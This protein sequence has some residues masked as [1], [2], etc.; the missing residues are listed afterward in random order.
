MSRHQIPTAAFRTFTSSQYTDAVAYLQSNPFASGRCVIKASGLASGKGVL[1]PETDAEALEALKSVMVDRE[2]GDAGDEVVV[3]EF[4]TGPEISVLAFCDGYTCVPMPAAQD[5]KR[6]G[7]GDV[8]LNTGGMGAYAPAPVATKEIME[9]CVKD[10][11][12][13]TLRGMREDG[14]CLFWWCVRCS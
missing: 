9:R 3:E 14:E 8:G 1:I 12:E 2:F 4:M 11:L 10:C 13:P 5:H 6:I 7:E